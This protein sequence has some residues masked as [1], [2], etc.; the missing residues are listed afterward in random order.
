VF[1]VGGMSAVTVRHGKY[2]TSYSNLSSVSVTKGQNIKTGQS[3]GRVGTNLDGEGQL[4]F[5]MSKEN[6]FMNPSS[7][8]RRH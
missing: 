7:W 6:Q 4:D 5:I 3:V 1:D 8:L 2:F